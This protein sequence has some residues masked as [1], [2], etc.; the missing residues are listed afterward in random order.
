MKVDYVVTFDDGT[1]YTSSFEKPA[2]YH[3]M[4][5]YLG[6]LA[7]KQALTQNPGKTAVKAE[8]RN[9]TTAH[10]NGIV[11]TGKLSG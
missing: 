11:W 2:G 1:E 8:R 3:P 9:G 4:A 6:E 5:A 10:H 7:V